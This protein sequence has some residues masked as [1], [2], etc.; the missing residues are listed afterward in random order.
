ML[1]FQV[2]VQRVVIPFDF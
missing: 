1:L 2:E